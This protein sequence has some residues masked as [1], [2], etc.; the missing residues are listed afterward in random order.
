MARAILDALEDPRIQERLA[1]PDQHHVLGARPAL[2]DQ[3]VEDLRRHVRLRLRVRFPRAHR[4]VQVAFGGGLDDILDRQPVRLGLPPQ[5]SPQE[6]GPVPG[7]HR[8]FI[9]AAGCPP[10]SE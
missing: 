2:L 8:S 1:Q 7:A 10:A 9:V 6:L 5:I 4:A 3:P